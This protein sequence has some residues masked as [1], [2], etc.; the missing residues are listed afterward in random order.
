[1]QAARLND[2][3]FWVN[4]GNKKN[5][6]IEDGGG[7][8]KSGSRRQDLSTSSQ[9]DCIPLALRAPRRD[10]MRRPVRIILNF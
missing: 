6:R 8:E 3:A 2:T 7:E 1:M 4:L 9:H 10:A 5:K